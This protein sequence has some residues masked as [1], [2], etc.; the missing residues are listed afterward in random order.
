MY[1]FS[2]ISMFFL[3][4]SNSIHIFKYFILKVTQSMENANVVNVIHMGHKRCN[5]IE[6]M[7][8]AFVNRAVADQNAMN[9]HEATPANGLIA[10][11]AANVSTIGM[12]F[13]KH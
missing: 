7:E 5:A 3:D 4:K 10:K 13:C 9:V 8:H 11:L 12:Q 2:A 1:S 6:T